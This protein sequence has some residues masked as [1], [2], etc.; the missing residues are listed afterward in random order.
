MSMVDV[1]HSLSKFKEEGATIYDASYS[2]EVNGKVVEVVGHD[3]TH[4]I[5]VLNGQIQ[6]IT[7]KE[8]SEGESC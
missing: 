6:L 5:V 8:Y 4:Y 3:G 2:R 1:R 7:T